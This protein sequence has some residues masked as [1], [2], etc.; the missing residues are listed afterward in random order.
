MKIL[1]VIKKFKGK[2]D[3]GKV[4][5]GILY[6]M[7]ARYPYHDNE[8]EIIAKVWLIGRAYAASIERNKNKDNISDDFYADIVAPKFKNHFDKLLLKI[9]NI[10]TVKEDDIGAI[11]K[12]HKKVVDFIYEITKDNKRSFT[13]KYLHFHFPSLFF[14]YDSR[15]AR[16][17]NKIFKEIGGTQKDVKRLTD[18]LREYDS[19]YANFFVRCF[20]FWKFCEKERNHL[21]IRQIDSF[22]IQRANEKIRNT[23]N[24]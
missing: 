19:A 17:I 5:N 21:D 1:E 13:S 12:T 8:S 16:V 3:L 11:L 7:C 10:S 23:K 20:Y 22:L 4:G 9:R 6:D 18:S 24:K 14:I 2:P 15:V